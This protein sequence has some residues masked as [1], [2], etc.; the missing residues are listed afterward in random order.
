MK[1]F[2]SFVAVVA[3]SFT[4]AAVAQEESS[5]PAATS[6]ETPAAS[7]EATSAAT[8]EATPASSLGEK[9]T[10]A[11]SPAKKETSAT[12]TGAGKKASSATS[13]AKTEAAPAAAQPGKKMGVDA[14][15]REMENKWEAA[16]GS[17]DAATIGSFVAND[18][19]GVSS[20]GKFINKA[21]LLAET[22]SDKDTYKSTRNER[23]DVRVY[24]SN[25]AVA[26]GT[27]RE[28]GTG[29]DGKAFDRSYRFTDTWLA[30]NGKW[31]CIASQA[32]LAAGK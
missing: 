29:K 6:E 25:A 3:L 23:L 26:T 7:V 15:I 32:T 11:A 12:A 30:R 4:L 20:K 21:G 8:P 2:N 24:A 5:S 16:V 27:A 13:S 17:H 18:F 22:K 14:A 1:M 28:K 9:S 19:M 31:Q 10:K